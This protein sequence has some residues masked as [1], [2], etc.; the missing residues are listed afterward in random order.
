VVK[1]DVDVFGLSFNDAGVDEVESSLVVAPDRYS[2]EEGL[3]RV[4]RG[5]NV[6]D[7]PF[8]PK[9]FSRGI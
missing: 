2:G 3:R 7:K 6:V 8:Q 4:L 5:E 1:L 9:G